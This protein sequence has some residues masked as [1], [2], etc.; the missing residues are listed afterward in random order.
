MSAFDE[1]AAIVARLRG[2]GGCP[3]DTAQ[4]PRT[5]RPYLLEETYE[6]LDAIESGDPARLREELGDL[7]FNVVMLAQ[8][9]QDAGWFR[10]DEVPAGIKDKMIERHPHVFGGASGGSIADWEQ[11]KATV[12]RGRL[13]GVPRMLPALLRAH[14]Q[15][16]K[17]AAVGFDW[18][19]AAGVLAKVHEEIAELEAEL[20]DAQRAEE[21]LGDLLMAVASLGRKLGVP[22]ESALQNANDRFRS[23]FQEME[24]LAAAQGAEL[25]SLDAAALDALW[26]EAKRSERG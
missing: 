26:E 17:A 6:V 19:D 18:D 8:M 4:D 14:R 9:A 25:S 23:R 11:R 1:L 2:P 15:G 10:V 3:W 7:L 24:R 16:E 21:E 20:G 22:P 13:D 12:E 5:M